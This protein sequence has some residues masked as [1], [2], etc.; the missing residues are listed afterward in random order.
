MENNKE[1]LTDLDKA[2]E[3]FEYEMTEVLL[4]FKNEVKQNMHRD[5]NAEYMQM[6]TPS[7]GVEF[8]PPE[9]DIKGPEG[10][11]QVGTAKISA[12]GL[13][14]A[15][16]EIKGISLPASGFGFKAAAFEGAD[17]G[18]GVKIAV[19][20]STVKSEGFGIPAAGEVEARVSA[21]IKALSTANIA[22]AGKGIKAAETELAGVKIADVPSPKAVPKDGP[23]EIG[24]LGVKVPDTEG[25]QLK[26]QIPA[27]AEPEVKA[28]ISLPDI[29]A[30]AIAAGRADEVEIKVKVDEGKSFEDTVSEMQKPQPAIVYPEIPPM[31][32]FSS[33]INDIL[34]TVRSEI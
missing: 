6:E 21:E 23:V 18:E 14:A 8:T 22:E 29:D 24:S 16:I 1:A 15:D 20:S 31:P 13:S 3:I 26:A 12:E 17:V 25:K 32:D 28:G 19:P 33:D 34:N 5:I 2:K 4:G 7:A 11:P 27:A 30:A 9:V 10:I